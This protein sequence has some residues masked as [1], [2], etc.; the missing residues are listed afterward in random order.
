ARARPSSSLRHVSTRFT[1]S[2]MRSFES[3]VAVHTNDR[4]TMTRNLGRSFSRL[5]PRAC[6]VL[7]LTLGSCADPAPATESP[8]TDLSGA[9]SVGALPILTIGREGDPRYEFTEIVGAGQLSSGDWVIFDRG[10]RQLRIFS[11]NGNHVR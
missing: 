3:S 2:D 9:V 4:R 5:G 6:T 1:L 7:A 11:D 8:G 10:S